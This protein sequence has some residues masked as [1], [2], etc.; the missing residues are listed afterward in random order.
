MHSS[1]QH[2][3]S[4]G[5]ASVLQPAGQHSDYGVTGDEMASFP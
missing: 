1:T 5:T 4:G 2:L 3:T